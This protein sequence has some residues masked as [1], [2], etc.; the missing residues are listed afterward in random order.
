MIAAQT[1]E[2]VRI[3]AYLA[4]QGMASRRQIEAWIRAG[5][6][7]VNGKPAK[8]GQKIT[9]GADEIRFRGKNIRPQT[10][11]ENSVLIALHKPRGVITTAK[12]PRGRT[13][14]LDLLP[15]QSQ[16]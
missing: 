3:H 6:F 7:Q 1:K 13:T 10:S 15:H 2:N 9:P 4:G 11:A 12:D 5:L 14:V 8:L 16:T